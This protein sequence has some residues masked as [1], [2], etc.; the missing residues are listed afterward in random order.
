MCGKLYCGDRVKEDKTDYTTELIKGRRQ[1]PATE[2]NRLFGANVSGSR[3][4]LQKVPPRNY[5][6][7]ND[8]FEGY[9]ASR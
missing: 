3:D 4:V 1:L 8:L 9:E 6:I 5:Q 7:I 2:V